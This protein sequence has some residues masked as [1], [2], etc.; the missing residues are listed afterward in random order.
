M[1]IIWFWFLYH[2]QHKRDFQKSLTGIFKLCCKQKPVDN[3]LLKS[4]YLTYVTNSLA[5]KW[6]IAQKTSYKT[7]FLNK[8]WQWVIE[9]YMINSK[10][11]NFYQGL[12]KRLLTKESINLFWKDRLKSVNR[13]N[14]KLNKRLRK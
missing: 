8:S 11:Q 2:E 1:I 4:K 6:L 12:S 13:I 9:N 10:I 7:I 5:I 14:F 3:R